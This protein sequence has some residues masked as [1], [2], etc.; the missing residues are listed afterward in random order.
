MTLFHLL[1]LRFS[2]MI[3]RLIAIMLASLI[4][5]AAS[6][7][8]MYFSTSKMAD[9]TKVAEEV[10]SEVDAAVKAVVAAKTAGRQVD[11]DAW[12]Q[13]VVPDSVPFEGIFAEFNL[14][15]DTLM[16]LE[17]LPPIFF[18][19]AVFRTYEFPDTIHPFTPDYSGLPEMRWI[20][21]VEAQK[22]AL[23]RIQDVVFYSH[24]D[25]VRYNLSMLPEAPKVYHAV[26]NPEDHTIKIEELPAKSKDTGPTVAGT[27]VQKK[28]W[29]RNFSA[30]LQFSQAYVSPNWYQGGNSNMN[31]FGNIRYD[32]SLNQSYHPNIKFETT[33]QYKVG[34][35]NAPED[36]IHSYN[37]IDD[38]LQINT[39][40]G[41]KAAKRWYYSFTGQFKTQ[42]LNSYPS[43]SR[44]L[45]SAFLSPGDLNLGI[46]M[47]YNY[48][49]K[50]KTFT[51]DASINPL[52]Y[53]LKISTNSKIDP[54]R[55]GIDKG[56]KTAHNYGSNTE[57]KL[58]WK[59]CYNITYRSR[60]FAFSDY[61]SFYADW[62]NTVIFEINRFLTTELRANLRYDT[63]TPD[64][65]DPSWK[66][67]QVK[68]ILSIGF[69]YK[70]SSL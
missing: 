59:L 26:V 15:Y 38:L 33:F 49:N 43:N 56:H 47:T 42:L 7:Q 27:V 23:K 20:E 35:N 10:R 46:G 2:M 51:F 61:E 25:V 65:D 39:T 50:K 1:E 55:Y 54:G 64:C 40:F 30:G 21:T 29:I 17:K 24:P 14:P 31:M 4:A 8:A 62:E 18:M 32:V 11:N 12:N 36:S 45:R 41:I 13:F 16:M 3:R 6:A 67:L 28:H 58:F 68:E 44:N 60:M 63:E 70:F 57:L 34:I 53:N 22:R 52:S 19:P 5:V 37:I 69:A 48:N 9:S 66:K